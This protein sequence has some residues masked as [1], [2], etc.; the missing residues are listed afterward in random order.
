VRGVYAELRELLQGGGQ[1]TL[2]TA[3][4]PGGI[5]RSLLREEAAAPGLRFWR[6]GEN[7]TLRETFFPPPRLILFGCG[8]VALPLARMAAL[9]KFEVILFDD[10]PS[11][12]DPR[13]FPG[14]AQVICDAFASIPA[15][16]SIRAGDYVVIITRGH[17]YDQD[18]LRQVLS[19]VFPR[20]VGMIGSRRRAGIVLRR[21]V[22]EGHAEEL[23][24]RVHAPIGL[25]IGAVT[26]EEIA[27]SIL[28]QVVRTRRVRDIPDAGGAEGEGL[29]R[30]VLEWLAGEHAERAALVT[31]LAARGST[32][33]EAGARL[34]LL[35]DGSLLGSIGGGCAEAEVLR[36]ARGVLSGGG[37][38]L[39]V[40][41]LADSAAEEE[42]MV[43]GGA[44]EVLIEAV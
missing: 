13:R 10:R 9:L 12:A 21:M 19:G 30:A 29:D 35:E 17:R 31:V 5:E 2:V 4:S 25:D 3:L 1:V 40:S 26:P 39:A 24:R 18:C 16:L 15:R 6:E 11:F 27:L 14:A 38:R 33:R 20:Y 7:L 44:M 36:Q 22:E 28:A 41:D 32:P 34:L 42:G 23:T 37:W 8:H 43:C